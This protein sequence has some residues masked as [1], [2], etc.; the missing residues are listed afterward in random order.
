[1]FKSQIKIIYLSYSTVIRTYSIRMYN[2]MT[3]H[4]DV[5]LPVLITT[6]TFL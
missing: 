4:N 5:K 2:A 1:M 3:A 6:S